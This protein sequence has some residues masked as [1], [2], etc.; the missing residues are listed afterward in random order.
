MRKLLGKQRYNIKGHSIIMFLL[1]GGVGE[2]VDQNA[3]TCK[4][5]E[6]GKGYVNVKVY[7]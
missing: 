1:R 6:R 7:K 2:G 5:R 3:N 4:Q